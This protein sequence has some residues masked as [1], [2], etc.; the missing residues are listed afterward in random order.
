MRRNA[1]D[2]NGDHRRNI[3]EISL[4]FDAPF[5][6]VL[7]MTGVRTR[8]FAGRDDCTHKV[9]VLRLDPVTTLLMFRE[10]FR[11]HEINHVFDLILRISCPEF[12]SRTLDI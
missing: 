8:S 7:A 11:K 12:H 3:Q 9:L 4:N 5:F 6:K 1:W 2:N 10:G